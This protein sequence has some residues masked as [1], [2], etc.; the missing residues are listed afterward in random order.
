MG[1]ELS[2]R[3]PRL[4]C[5]SLVHRLRRPN[6]SAELGPRDSVGVVGVHRNGGFRLSIASP[7][8][9]PMIQLLTRGG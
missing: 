6:P 9:Y 7:C 5:V 4:P 8:E 2:I 1:C 3:C